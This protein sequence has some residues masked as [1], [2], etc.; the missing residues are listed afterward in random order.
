M[1]PGVLDDDDEA[2]NESIRTIMYKLA[3]P[4]ESF[5]PYS[6]D[7]QARKYRRVPWTLQVKCPSVK[8]KSC[9]CFSGYTHLLVIIHPFTIRSLEFD[10]S[11]RRST[12]DSH[13]LPDPLE[14]KGVN[15][16]VP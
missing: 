4:T 5:M 3:V 2:Q 11:E 9:H 8:S 6:I 10:L 15:F 12:L 16:E 14:D 13:A 7:F 1:Y